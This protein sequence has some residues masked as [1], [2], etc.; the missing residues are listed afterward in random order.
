MDSIFNSL[1]SKTSQAQPLPKTCLNG[2]GQF[3]LWFAAAVLL[4]HLP[5]QR[6]VVM[7][8]ALIT[9]G[10]ADFFRNG[11]QILEQVLDGFFAEVRE[12]GNGLVQIR[13][14]SSVMLVVVN[15]H[16]LRVNVR[17]K[18]VGGVGQRRRG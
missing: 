17:F 3:V 13:N 14:I 10:G 16:C 9:D 11:I 2:F 4:H 6:M 7:T 5:E 15:L 8:T 1:P 12:I 18:R